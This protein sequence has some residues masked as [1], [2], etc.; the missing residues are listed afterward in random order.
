M[1]LLVNISI[2]NLS[3]IIPVHGVGLNIH[4]QTS[5]YVSLA[6][7]TSF[8]YMTLLFGGFD[9]FDIGCLMTTQTLH[10]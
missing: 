5:L 1:P 8:A 6:C 7:S 2:A 9:P 4:E 10:Y 3:E